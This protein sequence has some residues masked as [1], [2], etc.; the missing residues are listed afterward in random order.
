MNI[1]AFLS[2]NAHVSIRLNVDK[3]TITQITMIFQ[4][5]REYPWHDHPLLSWNICPILPSGPDLD[6]DVLQPEQYVMSITSLL[7]ENHLPEGVEFDLSAGRQLISMLEKGYPSPVHPRHPSFCGSHQGTIVF[8]PY[9][10][11]YSC[12]EAVRDSRFIIGSLSKAAHA[13]DIANIEQS[14]W[15]PDQDEACSDCAYVLICGGGCV[16]RNCSNNADVKSLLCRWVEASVKLALLG[17]SGAIPYRKHT[18]W[19]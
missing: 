13:D 4:K 19:M 14:H 2:N 10:D 17:L 8:D 3:D 15:S 9:G 5:I 6:F 16:H 1:E 12:H 11:I 7:S 18:G